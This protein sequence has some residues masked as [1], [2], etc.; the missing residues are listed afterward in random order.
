MKHTFLFSEGLWIASG[1]YFDGEG[2]ATTVKGHSRVVH[3]ERWNVESFMQL[4]NDEKL[5]FATDYIVEPF[6]PGA[7]STLWRSHHP[8][9]GALNGR[10]FLVA[11]TILSIYASENGDYTGSEFMLQF[12]DNSYLNRGALFHL[13]RRLSSWAVELTRAGK[14]PS[15]PPA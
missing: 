6:A 12:D 10:F 3:G 9:I 14:N 15:R 4:R 8:D 11:D 5:T 2:R 1:N 7:D 13:Q